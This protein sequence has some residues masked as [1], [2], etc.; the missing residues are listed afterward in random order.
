MTKEIIE[1]VDEVNEIIFQKNKE[2]LGISVSCTYSYVEAIILDTFS[3]SLLL[4]HSEDDDRIYLGEETD[5]YESYKDMIIR[6]IKEY[7]STINSLKL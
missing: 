2:D 3:G 1:A 6:K 7:Q 4:W 5:T